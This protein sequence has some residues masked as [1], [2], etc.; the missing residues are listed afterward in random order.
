L[1]F[2]SE[3]GAEP[4]S[5]KRI[6][7]LALS[8]S[9]V[10]AAAAADEQRAFAAYREQR[11]L[12]LPQFIIG[13]GLGASYGFPLSLEGSAPSIINVNSQSA[14]FNPALRDFVRSTKTDW[15]AT[16]VQSKD[17]R[18]QV[19]QDTVLSYAELAKWQATLARL[20]QE[21]ADAARMEQVVAERI[22]EGLDTSLERTRAQLTSARVRYRIAEAH[23]AI[24]ILRDRLAHSTG[25]A[26]Q[27]IDGVP[28]SIPA[29]P[30]IK[31]DENLAA[32]AM[33][34]NPAV[35]AADI[36]ATGLEYRAR[37]EHRAMWP[38]VDFAAQYALLSRFNNYDQFYKAFQRNNAS[39][40]V[41]IRF[42]FFN[43]SQHARAEAA[44][45]EALRAKHD[46]QTT[47]NNVSAE[48]L[49]LQRSVEQLAAA[50]QVAELEYQI[51]QSSLDALQVRFDAG[52]STLH[53][54]QDARDQANQRYD[55]LQDTTFELEKARITLLRSTGE[56]EAWIGK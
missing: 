30:E 16:Q 6:V 23:G 33:R 39:I 41:A 21:Q 14:L 51:A 26:P 1:L 45:A 28:E 42:P 50:Q 15:K 5:L 47:K 36:H 31:Q 56:L 22:Q 2:G 32:K 20:E 9:S 48:T 27:S 11:N 25:L 37:A 24:D 10:S 29:L 34:D 38:M 19:I 54:V 40:G 3:A 55:A 17:Q 7:E 8:H 4:I 52:T 49:R 53:D 44:D 18:N 12:Y 35:N 13:S 46:A 43:W